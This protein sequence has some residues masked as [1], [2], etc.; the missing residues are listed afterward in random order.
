MRLECCLF[1]CMCVLQFEKDIYA[2]AFI[3]D[4]CFD[5]SLFLALNHTHQ[6]GLVIFL[7]NFE[8]NSNLL[9]FLLY[10]CSK[11]LRSYTLR[12]KDP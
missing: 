4:I 10:F 1:L 12:M 8:E 7:Y 3:S 2:T 6:E 9:N 11:M 5:C